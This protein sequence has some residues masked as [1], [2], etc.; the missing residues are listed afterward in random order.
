LRKSHFCILAPWWPGSLCDFLKVVNRKHSS[1]LL[2]FWFWENRLLVYAFWRQKDFKMAYLRHLGF[3]ESNNGK[4]AFLHFGVKIQDGGS[5]PF[6]I[7]GSNN[8]FFE[9]PTYDFIWV[10]NRHHS[11]KLLSICKNRIFA[12]WRQD[13]RWRIS[14]ILDCRIQ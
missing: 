13:P 12:F 4:I 10:V 8:G 14:A 2:T 9:K 5:P 11:S 7:L 3:W 1:K 6:W